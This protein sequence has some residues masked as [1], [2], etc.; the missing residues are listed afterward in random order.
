MYSRYLTIYVDQLLAWL[1]LLL[2]TIFSIF[3]MIRV[4][5]SDVIDK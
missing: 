4:S 1:L 2:D 5:V 3:Q